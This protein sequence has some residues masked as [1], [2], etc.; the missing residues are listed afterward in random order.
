MSTRFSM[1]RL[2]AIVIKEFIQILRDR[3]TFGMI[4]LMPLCGFVFVMDTGKVIAGGPPAA[5]VADEN[6]INSYLGAQA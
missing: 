3:S 2:H 6:V 1:P 5:I 4:F